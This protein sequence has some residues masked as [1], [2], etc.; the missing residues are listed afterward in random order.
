M[1]YLAKT[2]NLKKCLPVLLIAAAMVVG[3]T[4]ATVIHKL[5]MENP[6]KTPTVEGGIPEDL[7]NGAKKVAFVNDGEADVFLRVAFSETWTAKDGTI[8]PNETKLTANAAKADPVANPNWILNNWDTE[9]GDGWYYYKKVLPGSRSGQSNHS[10]GLIVDKVEFE[11][12]TKIPDT[13]YRDAHYE[14][15]FVME[16][17]QAS[18]DWKV[19][20]D[21]V[22][23]MFGID[24]GDTAPGNWDTNKYA[25]TISWPNE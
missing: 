24:L 18:D 22:Q 23:E 12:L 14:I 5:T 7:E 2:I 19:S 8:L 6:I 3:V 9:R 13:R 20:R 10:T 11:D 1:T 15:H 16:M 21:A 17:V 25:V 4:G